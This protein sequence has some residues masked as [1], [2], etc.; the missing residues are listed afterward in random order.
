MLVAM[1]QGGGH[2]AE[3]RGG[4]GLRE[5]PVITCLAAAGLSHSTQDLPCGT[6]AHLLCGTRDLSSPDQG[7]NP[8]P[9]HCKGDSEPLDHQEVPTTAALNH[10]RR[11]LST[12]TV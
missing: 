2:L 6:Q 1:R 7:L 5:V 4:L 12:A 11:F 8:R 10:T 3:E 9:L